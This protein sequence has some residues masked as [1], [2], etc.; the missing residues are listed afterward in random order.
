M[1]P[2]Q[3]NDWLQ[4]DAAWVAFRADGNQQNVALMCFSPE[5]DLVG[6]V[7]VGV[8]G[9]D[10]LRQVHERRELP[11]AAVPALFA[12]HFF[13]ETFVWWGLDGQVPWSV[14]RAAT[15][16]YLFIALVVVPCVVPIAV[17]L[18]EP[19]ARRRKWM[20][21]FCTVGCTVALIML[22]ALLS[23]PFSARMENHCIRYETQLPF[24][25][26]LTALYVLGTCGVLLLSSSRRILA[27]GVANL[28]VVIALAWLMANALIS[29]WCA[30][31]AITS[32]VID[33][34]LRHHNREREDRRRTTDADATGAEGPLI[35]H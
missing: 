10:T 24:G 18:V 6:A 20:I 25:G 15:W 27:F 14:G 7:A 21:G 12:G 1:I 33:L 2:A 11:L 31:A 28:V 19:D 3:S 23:G 29:L 16:L 34:R 9:V 5:A 22:F 35:P 32:I 17:M 30:W 26:Q 4:N 13:I 8:V